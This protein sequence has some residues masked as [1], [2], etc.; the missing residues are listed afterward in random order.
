M[1]RPLLSLLALLLATP[2]AAQTPPPTPLTVGADASPLD[3]RLPPRYRRACPDLRACCVP[4]MSECWHPGAARLILAGASGL[5]F[6]ISSLTFLNAGDS[7]SSG[8]PLGQGVGMSLIGAAGAGLGALMGLLAPNGE[9]AVRDRPGRPTLRVRLNQRGSNTWDEAAP[10]SLTLSADPT[11]EFGEVVQLQPHISGSFR[12]GRDRTVDPRPQL[13]STGRDGQG[14]FPEALTTNRWKVSAGAEVT[15]RLPYP[16]LRAP[17]APGLGRFELRYRPQVEVRRRA[18]HA[19]TDDA[20]FIEHIALYPAL[21]G[22]RWHVSPRQRLTLFGGPR[23]DWIGSGEPGGDQIAHGGP[24]LGTFHGEAWYQADIPFP[25]RQPRKIQVSGRLN[26]GYVHSNLDG[27]SLD[28]GAIVGFFGPVNVSWDLRIRA[29]DAPVAVQITAGVW[30]SDGP[31]P[32][33]EL[34]FVAPQMKVRP[35]KAAAGEES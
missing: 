34:G 19:G 32:Y 9:T 1:S 13:Q 23:L 25:Q 35:K 2:A 7:L 28:I 5:G 11:I 29:A 17:K 24:L 3:L 4:G 6:A 30:V 31:A 27:K 14:L 8:D 10:W 12:F 18:V 21:A 26:L 33:L 20:R 15:V 22:L 16:L